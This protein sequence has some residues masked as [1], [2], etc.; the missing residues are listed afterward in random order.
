MSSIEIALKALNFHWK[1][2]H[3]NHIAENIVFKKRNVSFLAINALFRT[4]NYELEYDEPPFEKSYMIRNFVEV[5]PNNL[6]RQRA[7]M[8]TVIFRIDAHHN[9]IPVTAFSEHDKS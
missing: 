4:K 9:I 1:P 7:E 3:L 8:L 6:L 5:L 2:K